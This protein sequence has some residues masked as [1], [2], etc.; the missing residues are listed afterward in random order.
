VYEADTRLLRL[1]VNGNLAATA[2]GV[3]LE[4]AL[5]V[6][7]VG[8]GRVNSASAGFFVGAIDD[9]RNYRGALDDAQIRDL[10]IR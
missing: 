10:A 3:T 4:N 8:R 1:Y 7:A 5:G 9:V 2:D 6:F